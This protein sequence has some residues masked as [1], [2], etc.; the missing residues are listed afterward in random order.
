M[1]SARTSQLVTRKQRVQALFQQGKLKQAKVLYEKL[2]RDNTT[3]AESRYMLGSVYGRLGKFEE[4]ARYFRQCIG[5]QPSAFVAHCGLGAALKELGDYAEAESTFRDALKLQ[6]NNADVLLELANTLLNQGNLSEAERC[7]HQALQVQPDS[8]DVLHGLG[9]IS[10]AKRHLPEAISFYERA[11]K[12]DAN[13]PVTHNRLGLVLQAIG[14]PHDA[15]EHYRMALKIS[16]GLPEAYCNMARALIAVGKTPEAKTAYLQAKKLRPEYVEAIVGEAALD[17]REGNF[18]A[19]Y[20]KLAP[21]VERGVQHPELAVAYANLCRH[22]GRCEQAVD[23]AEQLLTNTLPDSTRVE[24]HFVLGKLYDSFKSYDEAFEHCRQANSLE[25]EGFDPVEQPAMVEALINTFDWNFLAT[26]PRATRRSQR[27]VFIVGMP[28]SGT[29]LTEQILASHPAVFGAGELMNIMNQ[30]AQ[31]LHLLG[32]EPGFPQVMR[33]ITSEVLDSLATDYLDYLKELDA[34]ASRV[35]DKM[36]LNFM[37]LG[38]IALEFPET[39]VIHCVRDPRDTCLSIYFQRFSESHAYARDLRHLGAY[40]V[41]YTKM[42][43]HWKSLLD[44]PILEVRYED[45]VTQQEETSRKLVDFVG[46]DWDERCLNFHESGRNVA[47]P[48][49]YQVR[50]PMYTGSMAR[51]KNYEKHI[52][53]LIETLGDTL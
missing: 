7:L 43:Q 32:P 16:A 13:R 23:Y 2:C 15:I 50:Q 28:R 11:L 53:P 21:L 10:H 44:I 18:D 36:P 47:T 38:L 48:S 40:Y 12:R 42:M 24:L 37:H 19:A 34:N 17:E 22:V 6:P 20:G 33:K 49:Y 14:K 31:L 41:Q 35:T 4:A 26:A 3:D 51:W 27:P 46:L 30:A 25:S 29:T 39:W 45:L 5:I 52:G 9:E 8:T 1:N